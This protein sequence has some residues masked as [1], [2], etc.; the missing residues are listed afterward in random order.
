MFR[1][2][3]IQRKRKEKM[4]AKTFDYEDDGNELV[5]RAERL[6]AKERATLKHSRLSK[7]TK[8]QLTRKHR[9]PSVSNNFLFNL[10]NVYYYRLDLH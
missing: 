3:K 2:H 8:E 6:R 1:F 5:E 10:F 9:D 4:E 7:W